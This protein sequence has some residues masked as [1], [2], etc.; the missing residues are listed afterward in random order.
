MELFLILHM[1]ARYVE[2]KAYIH[3]MLARRHTFFLSRFLVCDMFL[4][5]Y[6]C[7]LTFGLNMC[8]CSLTAGRLTSGVKSITII[9]SGGVLLQ[10][11]IFLWILLLY[12]LAVFTCS[13]L[14][15]C[16]L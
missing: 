3:S 10:A 8:Q 7:D 12:R 5:C 11:I 9:V 16:R 13:V 4:V 6:I 2:L 14:Q 15:F 1:H